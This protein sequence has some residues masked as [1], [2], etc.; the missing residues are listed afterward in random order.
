MLAN[1]IHTKVLVI[2]RSRTLAPL[3]PNL[4]LDDTLVERV[5]E[6]KVLG[7]VLDVKVSFEG[8]IT[9]IAATASSKIR[10]M[11]KALCLFGDPVLVFEVLLELPDSFGRVLLS[12]FD[13]C[14]SFSSLSS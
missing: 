4:V 3:L 6:L 11:R 8:H 9:S 12:C 1:P 14:C 5:T 7:V 10:I 2:S 13:V